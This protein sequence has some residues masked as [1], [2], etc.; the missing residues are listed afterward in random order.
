MADGEI[1]E[2]G[3]S[4]GSDGAEKGAS[5]VARSFE[6]IA[7]A[8]GKSVNQMTSDWRRWEQARADSDARVLQRQVEFEAAQRQSAEASRVQ[9]QAIAAV[10]NAQERLSQASMGGARDLGI[11][12]REMV[13]LVAQT[14]GTPILLDRIVSSLGTMSIGSGVMLGVVAG[15][16]AVSAV[17]RKFTEE[18]SADAKRAQDAIKALHDEMKKAQDVMGDVTLGAARAQVATA[19]QALAKARMLGQ[20][21]GPDG[22]VDPL[23]AADIK[24]RQKDL[25]KALADYAAAQQKKT[26]IDFKLKYEA[27]RNYDELLTAELRYNKNDQDARDKALTR[28]RQYT[29]EITRLR[30]S[31]T[32]NVRLV[33]DVGQ[34]DSLKSQLF[35]GQA[36]DTR[37]QDDEARALAQMVVL[38][39]ERVDAARALDDAASKG[40]AEYEKV[41]HTQEIDRQILQ[42]QYQILLKHL[43]VHGKIRAGEQQA[44]Q[45]EQHAAA[46]R[47]HAI[48]EYNQHAK[49]TLESAKESDATKSL[50]ERA[51]ALVAENAALASGATDRKDY[52]ANLAAE[53]EMRKA[54][55]TIHDPFQLIPRLLEIERLR[56]ATVAHNELTEAITRDGEARKHAL[57]DEQRFTDEQRRFADVMEKDVL[58]AIRSLSTN[59][60]SSIHAFGSEIERVSTQAYGQISA[61]SDKLRKSGEDAIYAGDQ[62]VEYAEKVR[63]SVEKLDKLKGPVGIVAAGVGG[64]MLGYQVGQQTGDSG[65]GAFGGAAAGAL[66]GSEF[67]PWG[68]VIGGLAGAAGGLLGASKA[69]EEAAAELERAARAFQ[70]GKEGYVAGSL[71]NSVA[72]Q[73]QA[74]LQQSSDL[75]MASAALYQQ[76][77]LTFAQHQ[78][79]INDLNDAYARYRQN[80]GDDFWGTI[81]QQLNALKGPAGEYQNQLDAI[82]KS[83]RQNVDAAK[84]LGASSAQLQ[85]IEDLRVQ[86]EKKLADAI[87]ET[88]RRAMEDLDVRQL[89]ATGYASAADDR[90]FQ[91]Q[92]QR[93]IIDARAAGKDESYIQML[94]AIQ[95]EEASARAQAEHVDRLT[96]AIQAQAADQQRA[97]D[98]QIA[99]AQDALKVAQDQ[100][101]AQEQTVQATQKAYDSLSQFAASLSLN[102]SLTALSP[103]AQ[104]AEAKRQYDAQLA[105]AKGGDRNA[106]AGL[107]GFAQTYLTDS[108][109][110]NA[111]GPDYVAQFY[112]V[113]ADLAK[114]TTQYGGALSYEQQTLQ[115]LQLQNNTLSNQLSELQAARAQAAADAQA[116]INAL[117]ASTLSI[118]KSLD[119][120]PGATDPFSTGSSGTS[121]VAT[122]ADGV[123]G[124]NSRLDLANDHL[125]ASVSAT[126]DGHLGTHALLGAVADR[127]DALANAVRAMADAQALR[128]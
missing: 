30:K 66:A 95:V 58:Q 71:R 17:W 121:S 67:G 90:A 114:L 60:L 83:Y 19:E 61:Y 59:G 113:Q 118:T 28:Y 70:T 50:K 10:S 48:D 53:V 93:E 20:G 33:F 27:D 74:A 46:D 31:Q 103:I 106:A 15:V 47:L 11:I 104:M 94:T 78:Q 107:S 36:A 79:N 64:A 23:M 7:A 14:S 51:D 34:A 112:Q 89:R 124:T 123:V 126:V 18:A 105:L 54:F 40:R 120:L 24:R 6:S 22:G 72:D 41:Q 25:E 69:H 45:D 35:P 3:V 99:V 44:V 62:Y 38:D 32:D 52:Q 82:E 116:Q 86:S 102:T 37:K 42:E 122:I 12:R 85:E 75:A 65:S 125:A 109:S 81:T 57:A 68:A 9:T 100:L 26:E 73:L 115:Q 56:A 96:K 87:A 63:Q 111:S 49:A 92:Q 97:Y 21:S 127:I 117:N 5:V 128:G 101:Q 13:S 84:A 2:Y 119:R 88:N 98:Q 55:D 91:L 76:D 16:A 1:S 39:N 29:D 4:I 43:D 80:I 110:V 108:R 8:S 77:K